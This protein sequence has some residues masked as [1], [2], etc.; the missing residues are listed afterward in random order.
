MASGVAS[1]G[2]NGEAGEFSGWWRGGVVGGGCATPPT[3]L[4][5]TGHHTRQQTHCGG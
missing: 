2:E 4:H 1:D 3:H 5:P